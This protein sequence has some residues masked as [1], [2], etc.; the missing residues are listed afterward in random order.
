M[1][2]D[3]FPGH[4][5]NNIEANCIQANWQWYQMKQ[6]ITVIKIKVTC[7]VQSVWKAHPLQQD[8]WIQIYINVTL[9]RSI[10]VFSDECNSNLTLRLKPKNQIQGFNHWV[11]NIFNQQFQNYGA[12]TSKFNFR[13]MWKC[14]RAPQYILKNSVGR[15]LEFTSFWQLSPVMVTKYLHLDSI[16]QVLWT[17]QLQ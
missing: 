6:L 9:F 3:N 12:F 1:N 15:C 7:A 4:Q 2:G 11:I 10:T 16:K 17:H 8:F 13:L 5:I 14:P